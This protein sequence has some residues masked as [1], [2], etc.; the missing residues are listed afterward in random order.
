MKNKVTLCEAEID[1]ASIRTHEFIRKTENKDLRTV[2]VVDVSIGEEV[3]ADVIRPFSSLVWDYPQHNDPDFD[4]YIFA[5]CFQC[6]S[7]LSQ[8]SYSNWGF[9]CIKPH[10]QKPPDVSPDEDIYFNVIKGKVEV[11]LHTSKFVLKKGGSFIVPRG[12]HYSIAN[13]HK[14]K[15]ILVFNT[16]TV[17]VLDS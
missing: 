1:K 13:V 7:N 4:D 5:K 14:S 11:D 2:P 12:N 10:R 3:P 15:S 9:I 6:S 16:T 17:S 8:S